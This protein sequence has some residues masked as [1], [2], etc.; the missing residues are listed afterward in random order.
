[1]NYFFDETGKKLITIAIAVEILSFWVILINMK[2]EMKELKE[3]MKKL[4]R[5]WKFLN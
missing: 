4:K 1:M 3:N 5:L 2:E